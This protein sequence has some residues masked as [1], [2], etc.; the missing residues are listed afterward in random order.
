M[1]RPVS[2]SG[3]QREKSF[4]RRSGL[5]GADAFA[6]GVE[7]D[8]KARIG[9]DFACGALPLSAWAQEWLERGVIG[10]STHRNYEGFVRNHLVPHLGN[11]PLAGQARR[12]FE[13]FAKDIHGSGAGLAAATVNDRM[14]MVA[15]VLEA[16]VIDK[17]IPDNPARGIRVTRRDALA[18]GEDEIPAPAEVD[19]IAAHIAPQYRLTVYLQAGTGQRPSEALASSTEC[20]RPGSVRIRWQVSPKAHRE[21][22]RTAFVPLKNRVEGEYRDVPAAPFVEQE[23]DTHLFRWKPVPVVFAGRKKRRQLR[24]FSLRDSVART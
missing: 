5:D 6:A 14:V 3:R 12:A 19:L 15:A 10:E 4:P 21:D 1:D 8:N 2:G 9:F 22:C 11:R 7:S 18:V 16:A 24:S 13:K 17:R 23:V 20:R